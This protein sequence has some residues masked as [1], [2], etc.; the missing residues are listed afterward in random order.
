MFIL[1]KLLIIIC[2][3]IMVYQDIKE[4]AIWWFLFP[5][6]LISAGFLHLSNSPEGMLLLV[7]MFNIL[8]LTIILS[9][10]FLYVQFKMKVSFF[11][12]A[13]GTGDLLFFLI[14]S[15]AF[16]TVAFIV[17]LVFSLIF[18]L[19]LHLII[20]KQEQT[21]P[22]AGYS[23]LFLILVYSAHWTGVFKSLYSI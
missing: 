10:S 23:A 5:P 8:I 1:V 20:S 6:L 21:V 22:L 15:V 19:V 17:I 14:L 12:K 3:L 7:S 9:V 16:P 11:K 13:F 4:R 2:L 18:S